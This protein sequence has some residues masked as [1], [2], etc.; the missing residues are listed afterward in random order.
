MLSYFLDKMNPAS[1]YKDHV[2]YFWSGSAWAEFERISHEDLYHM[3]PD[4]RHPYM[5]RFTL[6]LERELFKDTSLRVTYINRRWKSLVGAVDRAAN[7]NLIDVTIPYQF[8][9]ATKKWEAGS[10]VYQVYERI[11]DTASSFD[12]LITNHS[13]ASSPWVL[14]NPVRKYDGMESSSISGSRTVGSCW[15]TRLG[16]DWN[17]GEFPSTGGTSLTISSSCAR[18]G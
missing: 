11:P 4:I 8:N 6:G 5:Q 12:Y 17:L 15:G 3:D 2:G 7:Y 13:T 1:A 16:H 9:S 10:S 14:L 18:P